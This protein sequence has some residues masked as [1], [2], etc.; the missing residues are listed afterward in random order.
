[1]ATYVKEELDPKLINASENGRILMV[2]IQREENK[3]L[4]VNSY[5]PNDQQEFFNDELQQEFLKREYKKYC[6]IGD[7]NAV[8]DKDLDK[9]TEKLNKKIKNVD[10]KKIL[11]NCR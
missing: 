6:M 5:A 2:E 4:L 9:K 11:A 7:L 3:C 1:M 8:F 10:S